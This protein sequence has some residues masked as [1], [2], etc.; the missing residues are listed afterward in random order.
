[1]SAHLENRLR[2]LRR[3]RGLSLEQLAA[4]A[5]GVHPTTVDRWERGAS[6]PDDQKVRVARFFGVPVHHIWLFD[7]LVTDPLS[8]AA[9]LLPEPEAKAS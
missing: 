7:T 2:K 5:D 6:C 8:E 9:L 4:I 3:A 1:M